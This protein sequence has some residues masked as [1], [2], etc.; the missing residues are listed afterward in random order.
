M[1]ECDCKDHQDLNHL[2]NLAPMYWGAISNSDEKFSTHF[3]P[4]LPFSS[5]PTETD[6]V[7]SVA[8]MAKLRNETASI[9]VEAALKHDRIA[10]NYGVR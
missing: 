7:G 1:K 6:M 8:A 4:W 3:P 5:P 9:F 2:H 10:P